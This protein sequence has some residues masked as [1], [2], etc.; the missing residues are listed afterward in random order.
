MVGAFVLLPRVVPF[1]HAATESAVL[2]GVPLGQL[3]Q[4]A[5]K[6]VAR[7]EGVVEA[8]AGN[9]PGHLLAGPE[10]IVARRVLPQRGDM[11]VILRQVEDKRRQLL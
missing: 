1:R 10:L 5:K 8:E 2:G 4:M 3:S 6:R 11:W 7:P 9:L